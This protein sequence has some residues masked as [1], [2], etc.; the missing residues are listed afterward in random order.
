MVVVSGRSLVGRVRESGKT[1][2][3][4]MLIN[5]IDA[6]V[7]AIVQEGRDQGLLIG[8]PEGRCKLIY[9]S[10][11][12]SVK[13]G[14]KILTSGM[15]GVYPKGILIGRVTKVAKEQ[16]RLYKYAIVEPSSELAKLEEVLC[17]K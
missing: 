3:K 8:T 15:G 7:G 12:S 1:M 4:V 5:D 9:I 10:L 16:G 11:D 2:S 14:D 17:I 6:K 13:E